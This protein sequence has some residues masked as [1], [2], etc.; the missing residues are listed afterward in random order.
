MNLFELYIPFKYE[1]L[2]QVMQL[3][4]S[5]DYMWTTDFKSGY[6]QIPMHPSAY[7]YL[8]VSWGG[9]LF[10][11]TYMP[12]GLASAC[13]VY[14]QL[15]ASVYKPLRRQG[16]R[17]SYIIDDAMGV[18]PD[19]HT[20]QFHAATNFRL[21]TGLGFT[22]SLPKCQLPP[23]QHSLFRGLEF[24]SRAGVCVVPEEK[25]QHFMAEM[26]PVLQRQSA[27]AKQL[28]SLAGT[29]MSFTPAVLTAPM[30]AR[31]FYE[32]LRGHSWGDTAIT[33]SADVC[34]DM[35]WWLQRLPACNGR[36][37]WHR[38]SSTI[39]A[40]DA[41]ERKYAAYVVQGEPAGF[42][43]QLDFTVTELQA[44]A[45]NRLGS[46]LREL[47]AIHQALCSLLQHHPQHVQHARIQWLSDSQAGI[48]DLRRMGAGTPQLLQAVRSIW[49]LAVTHDIDFDW[50]WRPRSSPELVLADLYSKEEDTGMRSY[51]RLCMKASWSWHHLSILIFS[52]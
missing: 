31:A 29:L 42:V 3:L 32:A 41:S 25:L 30:Q 39:I 34:Q 51:M 48:A 24:D 47:A 14:T 11:F 17:L 7:P 12:F 43:F 10:V 40:S 45:D 50:Q 16:E 21:L 6:H 28:A 19:Q 27:S 35:R 33:L 52:M 18:V 36:A 37:L 23:Q 13:R 46:T 4:N 26:Q 2:Q 1:S 20:G 49:M 44:M 22:F 15:M 8:G 5:G 38:Q 9:Q